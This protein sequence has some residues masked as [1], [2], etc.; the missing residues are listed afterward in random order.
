MRLRDL[1]TTGRSDILYLPPADIDEAP[2]FNLRPY[3]AAFEAKVRE[4]ADDMKARGFRPEFPVVVRTDGDRP[5]IVS[6]HTRR[7][8]AILAIAEGAPIKGIPCVPEAKGAN[9]ATRIA[10]ML[11]EPGTPLPPLAIAE[12]VR[13]MMAF[14]HKETEVAL[15][16]NKSVAWVK[17]QLVASSMPG[18][19][20]DAV[21]SGE[22]SA[23]N[24]V[25]MTRE[26][27]LAA[28]VKLRKAR[29]ALPVGKTRITAKT[30][31][32][33]AA[34]RPVALSAEQRAIAAF[35]A[36]WRTWSRRTAVKGLLTAEI[37]GRVERLDELL[38]HEHAAAAE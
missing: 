1:N 38:P 36:E 29:E 8:A 32:K 24:A 9:E 26:G 30:I 25:A 35:L 18:E 19:L 34:P 13:R 14:L 22:V 20:R 10:T 31:T 27:P 12:G 28:T 21:E 7:R 16:C 3:D 37:V 33:V 11:V 15:M 17:Q 4:Y 6:G 2:G 23:S 5:V